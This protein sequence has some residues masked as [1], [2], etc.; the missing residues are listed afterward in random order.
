[1][2]VGHE[3]RNERRIDQ[4]M[5]GWRGMGWIERAR[6]ARSGGQSTVEYALVGALVVIAAAGAMTLLGGEI[7]NIFTHITNTLQGAT[8]P[9]H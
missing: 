3:Q 5:K 4:S 6:S 2:S 9:A 8:P 7:N 1:M